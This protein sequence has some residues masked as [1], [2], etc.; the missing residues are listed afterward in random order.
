MHGYKY[1]Y[2]WQI[3]YNSFFIFLSMT[4]SFSIAGDDGD[5]GWNNPSFCNS[6]GRALKRI[7]E[8]NAQYQ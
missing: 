7:I 4:T 1:K 2:M 6:M 3:I 5:D 8:I